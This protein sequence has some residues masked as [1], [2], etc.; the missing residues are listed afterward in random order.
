MDKRKLKGAERLEKLGWPVV[1][2]EA[3]GG[4]PTL[5]YVRK[6]PLPAEGEQKIK[7][8]SPIHGPVEL[9]SAQ[10]WWWIFKKLS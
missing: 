4:N 6:K 7:A 10:E 3:G 1:A 8:W 9:L 5:V 2:H